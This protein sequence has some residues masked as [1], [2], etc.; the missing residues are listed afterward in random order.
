MSLDPWEGSQKAW[1]SITNFF[2]FSFNKVEMLL[3]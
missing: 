1:G 3:L 2:Q